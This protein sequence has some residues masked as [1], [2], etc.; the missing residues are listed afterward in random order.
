MS[1][2][3]LSKV[4]SRAIEEQ[5]AP[6]VNTVAS[7][8]SRRTVVPGASSWCPRLAPRV[9]VRFERARNRLLLINGRRSLELDDMATDVVRL[10][11]GRN[12]VR[13]IIGSLTESLGS[14][15]ATRL[16]RKVIGCLHALTAAALVLR[17]P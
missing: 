14:R 1:T 16:A 8:I 2:V 5:S 9:R 3:Y 13:A 6:R 4:R 7:S 11:T 17:G 10:C 15:R 12:S